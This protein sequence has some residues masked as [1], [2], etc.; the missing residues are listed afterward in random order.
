[1]AKYK[2]TTAFI[3]DTGVVEG[4]FGLV[5]PAEDGK[6]DKEAARLALKSGMEESGFENVFVTINDLVESCCGQ[7]KW[8]C[9]CGGL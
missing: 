7:P 2:V 9:R 4:A 8:A 3:V 5:V 1:M 6:V